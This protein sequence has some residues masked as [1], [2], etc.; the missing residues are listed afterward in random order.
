MDRN[1]F[2]RIE[3]CFPVLDPKL[4]KRVIEESLKIYLDDNAQAWDMD[5]DG[6]YKRGKSPKGKRMSAQAVV[7]EKLSIQPGPAT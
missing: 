6:H 2:R 5:G 3:V 7:L 1:F 4:K